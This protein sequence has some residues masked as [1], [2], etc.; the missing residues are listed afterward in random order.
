LVSVQCP[1]LLGEQWRGVA[2]AVGGDRVDEVG[3]QAAAL[4]S[5]G[6]VGR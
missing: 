1:A 3:V 5:A 2:A 6:G 4:E